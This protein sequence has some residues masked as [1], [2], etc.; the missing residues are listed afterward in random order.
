MKR[1][2]SGSAG[3]RGPQSRSVSFDV[4]PGPSTVGPHSG[5]VLERIEF[6]VLVAKPGFKR[7]GAWNG[8]ALRWDDGSVRHERAVLAEGSCQPDTGGLAT[9]PHFLEPVESRYLPE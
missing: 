1:P 4:V 3:E 7:T 2:A 6:A 8:A 5:R 9:N